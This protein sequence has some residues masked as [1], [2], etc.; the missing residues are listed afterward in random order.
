MSLDEFQKKLVEMAAEFPQGLIESIDRLVKTMHPKYKKEKGTNGEAENGSHRVEEKSKVFK[1]LAL[2]DRE[3]PW[4][5]YADA[6]EDGGANDGTNAIDDTLALLGRLKSKAGA[7]K[8]A[9]TSRKR[10]RSPD[11]D[12]DRGRSRKDKYRSRSQCV[13][14]RSR[15]KSGRR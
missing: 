2:P 3:F 1:G 6:Q 9:R 11:E 4:Q 14:H 15:R 7:D 12:Y 13:E 10:S 5:D 8:P